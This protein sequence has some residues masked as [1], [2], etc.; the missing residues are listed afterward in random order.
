MD[1]IMALLAGDSDDSRRRLMDGLLDGLDNDCVPCISNCLTEAIMSGELAGGEDGGVPDYYLCLFDCPEK[2]Y[3]APCSI[4][5]MVTI[6]QTSEQ[7]FTSMSSG[8]GDPGAIG[9]SM[10]SFFENPFENVEGLPKECTDCQTSC[11]QNTLAPALEALGSALENAFSGGDTGGLDSI[12]FEAEMGKFGFCSGC[13]S[14]MDMG[15]TFMPGSGATCKSEFKDSVPGMFKGSSGGSSSSDNTGMIVGIVVAVL[16][17]VGIGAGLG[18][19]YYTKESAPD[20]EGP[21]TP[22]RAGGEGEEPA[23]IG[24]PSIAEV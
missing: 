18:F 23:T 16:L 11:M 22:M 7:L 19:Y 5:D 3:D 24:E 14:G 12:D 10:E 4:E 13:C 21:S 2:E 8:G 1:D 6:Q 9:G 15:E 20:A 17:L